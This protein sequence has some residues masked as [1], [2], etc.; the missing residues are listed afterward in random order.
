ME[1]DTRKEWS[2]YWRQGHLTS[3]PRGFSSNYDGEFLQFWNAQFALLNPGGRI[4]DVCSGNGSIALLAQDYSD[5]KGLNFRIKA[6]D[7]AEIDVTSLVRQNPKLAKHIQAIQFQ[8]DTLLEDMNEEPESVD[9]VTSQFGVEY[10]E[11]QSSARNIYR[12]LKPGGYFSLICH[13]FDSKIT[14]Q[15]ER[16]QLDYA[17]LMDVDIFSRKIEFERSRDFPRSFVQQLDNALDT[18]YAIFK[19][20]RTSDVLSGVGRELENIRAL[21]IRDFAAG[22]QRF[23]QFRE[24]VKISYAT[25]SDLVAVNHRLQQF[26]NWYEVFIDAGF[27][28]SQS[29]DIHYHTAELAGR[30][31]Q[32]TKAG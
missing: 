13:S 14:T 5:R 20:N 4:L 27:E 10:T 28:L 32:F 25:A 16:Q 6:I 19:E 29:G 2:N 9:L 26:P 11:W 30:F 21:A 31:Y 23:T 8:P 17:L 15:M 7:A 18:I 12:A 22:F 24:G 1:I 3:L